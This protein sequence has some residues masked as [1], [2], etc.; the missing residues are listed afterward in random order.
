MKY[1]LTKWKKQI[2]VDDEDFEWLDK[3][4]WVINGNGYAVSK[5]NQK[6]IR[7]HRLILN[8]PSNLEVDHINGNRLDNQRSNLRLVTHQQ[9][10]WNRRIM[11]GGISKYKGVWWMKKQG[12]WRARIYKNRKPID[13][14]Y[15][16]SEVNAAIAYDRMAKNFYGEFAKLNFN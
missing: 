15:F 5:I 12:Y 16:D 11:P 7:I 4:S 9:N 2:L 10:Q 1:I 6:I 14:G 13:L 8:A 3:H